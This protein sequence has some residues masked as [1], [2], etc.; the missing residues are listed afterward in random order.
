LPTGKGLSRTRCVDTRG[1]SVILKSPAI[2]SHS[3]FRSYQSWQQAV[4]SL[5][6]KPCP[7]LLDCKDSARQIECDH[8]D[9]KE[10]KRKLGSTWRLR[11][12]SML[13]HRAPQSAV[14]I[15]MFSQIVR[16]LQDP[17]TK[18]WY[19]VDSKVARDKVGNALRDALKQRDGDSADQLIC[20]Q[21]KIQRGQMVQRDSSSWMLKNSSFT[22][23]RNEESSELEMDVSSQRPP[24][25]TPAGEPKILTQ[26]WGRPTA[27][28]LPQLPQLCQLKLPVSQSLIGFRLVDQCLQSMGQG[29][30]LRGASSFSRHN[31]TESLPACEPIMTSA[32]P[33]FQALGEQMED[34]EPRPIG[35]LR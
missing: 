15:S 21:R 24:V 33:D 31:V 2:Y 11:H 27:P 32:D 18:R 7:Q 34:L 23:P 1:C 6:R 10:H 35:M 3:R 19:H 28:L 26:S 16:S 12:E 5:H 25:V 22:F 4:S 13:S 17:K 8:W 14:D 20:R 30:L 9:R 29:T